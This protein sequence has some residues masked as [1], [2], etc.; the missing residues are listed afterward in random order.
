MVGQGAAEGSSLGVGEGSGEGASVTSEV[1]EGAAAGVG[2]PLHPASRSKSSRAASRNT[3]TRLFLILDTTFLSAL[4]SSDTRT[5]YYQRK[6]QPPQ[7]GRG[8]GLGSAAG[9]SE[10]R[11]EKKAFREARGPVCLS[12]YMVSRLSKVKLKLLL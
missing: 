7:G 10:N 9:R 4:R 3:G 6:P 2:P 5:G 12:V 1:G 11:R 8:S